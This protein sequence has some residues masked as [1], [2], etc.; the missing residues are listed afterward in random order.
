M[1]QGPVPH[2]GWGSESSA[3]KRGRQ[4]KAWPTTAHTP[5]V[6]VAQAVSPVRQDYF[7]ALPID[8]G[9]VVG[10]VTG[11][12]LLGFAHLRHQ[13]I[14][15]DGDPEARLRG[16][17]AMAILHWRQRFREEVGVLRIAA[18]LDEEV[19]DGRGNLQACRERA[20]SLRIVWRE[21]Q[22]VRLRH[23]E[24]DPELPDTA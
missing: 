9:T 6:L 1:P 10:V 20:R 17:F 8:D 24:H 7:S 3:R 2:S 19:R 23:P 18:L 11:A 15:V 4:A 5:P 13:L 21:R 22:V 12:V 14:L 16:Q